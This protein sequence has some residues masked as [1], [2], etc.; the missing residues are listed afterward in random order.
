M[1]VYEKPYL[2]VLKLISNEKIM[3]ESDDLGFNDD[4]SSDDDF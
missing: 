2:E 1:Y 3:T 4:E